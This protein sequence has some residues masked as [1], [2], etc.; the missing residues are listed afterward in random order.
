VKQYGRIKNRAAGEECTVEEG[1]RD[2]GTSQNGGFRIGKGKRV[3]SLKAC[4]LWVV[5]GRNF[6]EHSGGGPLSGKKRRGEGLKRIEGLAI[7][8]L[9]GLGAK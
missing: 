7:F 2:R 1:G 4:F 6:R 5:G 3:F 8:K 9:G